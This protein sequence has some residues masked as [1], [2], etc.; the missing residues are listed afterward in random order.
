MKQK[1]AYIL[2]GAVLMFLNFNPVVNA[3]AQDPEFF[4]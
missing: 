4:T 1:L 2:I 3:Q